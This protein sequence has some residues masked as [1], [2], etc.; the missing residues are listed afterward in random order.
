M[1]FLEDARE[2]LEQLLTDDFAE[3]VI[4]FPSGTVEQV[5][6]RGIFHS[7]YEQ[8]E[9]PNGALI[10]EE[11]PRLM[12]MIDDLDNKPKNNDKFEIRGIKYTVKHVEPNSRGNAVIYL[13][14]APV[15]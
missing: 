9:S 5:E 4:F 13:K 10:N 8:V 11:I 7:T 2:D 3:D 15:R 14:V 1:T 6:L 12:C